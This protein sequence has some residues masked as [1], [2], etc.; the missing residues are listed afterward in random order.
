MTFVFFLFVLD[1]LDFILFLC[2]NWTEDVLI[3]FSSFFIFA[4]GV[5][6]SVKK[7]A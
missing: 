4:S 6:F 1:I 3:P 7:R 5:G 2:G